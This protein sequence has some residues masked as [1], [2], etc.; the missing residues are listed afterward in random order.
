MLK[1]KVIST[2]LTMWSRTQK[3]SYLKYISSDQQG[4]KKQLKT[5]EKVVGR[6]EWEVTIQMWKELEI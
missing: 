6:A 3:Y 1:K 5:L 2:V 4:E